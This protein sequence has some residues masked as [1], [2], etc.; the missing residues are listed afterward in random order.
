MPENLG[1]LSPAVAALMELA[2]PAAEA[3]AAKVEVRAGKALSALNQQ[4][5][6]VLRPATPKA[7]RLVRVRHIAGEWSRLVA[8]D[9]ACRRGCSHC[10]HINTEVPRSE[11]QLI[12]K[13]SGRTLQEP[14]VKLGWTSTPPEKFL[15]VPCPF[16]R[17]GACSIYAHRPL[18]CR[19]LLSMAD[20]EA[21]CE[22]RP[23]ENV[24]VPYANA[25]ALQATFFQVAQ[26]EDWADIREWFAPGDPASSRG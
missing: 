24:P 9:A 2:G 3:N 25:T 4:L 5:R 21:L 15:G 18:A 16:L 12:A 10:C 6:I 8:P 11:A 7:Q 23:G 19:T 22:L 1:P 14:A 13:A 20:D 26:Q 17:D